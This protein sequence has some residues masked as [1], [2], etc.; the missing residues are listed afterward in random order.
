MERVLR[1]GL[2]KA[3]NWHLHRLLAEGIAPIKIDSRGGINAGAR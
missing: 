2:H 1:H 3:V